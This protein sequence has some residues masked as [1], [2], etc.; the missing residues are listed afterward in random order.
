MRPGRERG[1]PALVVSGLLVA[2]A[3]I[4]AAVA[5]AGSIE[6]YPSISGGFEPATLVFAAA[7]PVLAA[8][9][10]LSPRELRRIRGAG[11]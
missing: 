8:I 4:A 1:E 10:F 3:A 11:R 7:I 9:P 5:G 6:T 2:A